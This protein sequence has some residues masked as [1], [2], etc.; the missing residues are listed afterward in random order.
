VCKNID[1]VGYVAPGVMGGAGIADV[2][3]WVDPETDKEYALLGST[4]GVQILDVTDPSEPVYLGNLLGKPDGALI[5]QE[6]EILNDHLYAVCDL[7]PCGLQVF[8]LSRLRG[9][10]SALPVW[11]PDVVVPLGSAHSIDSNPETNHI[12]VNGGGVVVGTPVIFDV[13][14]PLA[15][16]P[17][18]AMTDDGYTHDS[19]CRNYHGPDKAYKGNEICFNFNEDTV[20]IYDVTSNPTRPVQLARE[21]YETASYVHS[22]ALTKDHKT[23]ISTDE[24]DEQRFGLP[25]TLYIWDVSKLTKPKLIGTWRGKSKSIDHNIYSEQNALFHANYVNGFRILDLRKAHKGK[26]SEVAYIDTVPT[27]DAPDFNG[28]WAAY[29]YLPSGNV[30]VGNMDGGLFIVRPEASVLKRLGVKR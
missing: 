14:Q 2:W 16:V 18:G 17:V 4:D 9:V 23:L 5:W 27:S 19:L 26:L 25:S 20:T 7:A 21:T 28:A 8:D 6:I 30:L 22:G 24:G 12:F 29:P 11:R 10:E 13:S 15:P 3:G 1:L